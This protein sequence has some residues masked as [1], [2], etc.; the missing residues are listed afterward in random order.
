[1]ENTAA[2]VKNHSL[3][4]FFALAYLLTWVLTPLI[5]ISP[6]LGVPGLLMP[7][8]AAVIVTR[9]TEGGAGVRRLLRGLLVWRTSPIW[10]AVALGLPVLLSLVIAYL[11]VLL[12]APNQIQF[13][14]LSPLAV[15]VFVLVVGE[16]VGW[17]GFAL[18]RLLERQSALQASLVLGLLW[19]L[20][21]L[22]TF[23]I[24]GTPQAGIPI[25]AHLVYVIALSVL[26]TWMYLHTRGSLLL[27]TLFHG[28][29]NTLGF[30][31][32]AVD[33]SLRWWLIAGV[34]AAAALVV[35]LVYGAQLK[36]LRR[37]D[38]G[39]G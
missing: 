18:P 12:G 9:M 32:P 27:A 20:W 2:Y 7:A 28:A 13:S 16:E 26:F 25:P 36:R 15:V 34:Y 11:G 24:P 23:F 22:P 14:P 19:G 17:R 33:P 4:V 29:V 39:Y 3:V 37:S 6:A 10:Y 5:A 31:N 8:I 1:M 38:G 30:I 35:L 21:H